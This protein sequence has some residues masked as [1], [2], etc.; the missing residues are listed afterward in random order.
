MVESTQSKLDR[1]IDSLM[2]LI[3]QQTKIALTNIYLTQLGVPINEREQFDQLIK[4]FVRNSNLFESI[5]AS[6]FY[7]LSSIG[8]NIV[9]NGG[10]LQYLEQEKISQ[11]EAKEHQKRLDR[12]TLDSADATVK[13]ARSAKSSMIAAWVSAG[14][15]LI[16]II[17]GGFQYIDGKEKDDEINELK[18]KFEKLDSLT[19]QK[20]QNV[21]QKS[22]LVD[23]SS[24][25][26]DSLK[27]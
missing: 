16:A 18:S 21:V 24:I 5:G 6:S 1:Y 12:A 10:Y 11:N 2:T 27:K 26:Q 22:H 9:E 23:S 8:F 13:S 19:S 15:A 20:L 25:H 3:F 17:I 7:R 14:L 4:D